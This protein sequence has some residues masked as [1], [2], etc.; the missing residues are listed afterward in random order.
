MN[1]LNNLFLNT[2]PIN[3]NRI[4]YLNANKNSWITYSNTNTLT[5]IRIQ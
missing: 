3:M 2:L 5:G 4:K 1:T